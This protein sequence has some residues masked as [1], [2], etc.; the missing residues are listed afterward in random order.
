MTAFGLFPLIICGNTLNSC[1]ATPSAVR[2]GAYTTFNAVFMLRCFSSSSIIGITYFSVTPTGHVERSM[3]NS[4]PFIYFVTVF[5]AFVMYVV[6]GI[7]STT[8]VSTQIMKVSGCSDNSSNSITGKKVFPK[9]L[10]KISFMPYSL[11]VGTLLLILSRMSR[12]ISTP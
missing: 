8:G 9:V 11:I 12:F 2:S 10:S 6:F 1:N 7:P 3:I 5:T 4:S